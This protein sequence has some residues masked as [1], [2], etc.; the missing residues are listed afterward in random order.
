MRFVTVPESVVLVDLVSGKRIQ[1]RLENGDIADEDPI[2]MAKCLMTMLLIDEKF[3]KGF[4][5]TISA[6]NIKIA[7]DKAQPGD[8][9][10]LEVRDWELLKEV[11]QSPTHGFPAMLSIQYVPFFRAID[12]AVP[13]RPNK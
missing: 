2:T 3:G 13:V 5:T 1:R 4:A 7:F 9:V 8:V 12:E 6:H 10:E 11:M